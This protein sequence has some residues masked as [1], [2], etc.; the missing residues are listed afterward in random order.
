MADPIIESGGWKSKQAA[1]EEEEGGLTAVAGFL[2]LGGLLT[3]YLAWAE[4]LWWSAAAVT[5]S[6]LAVRLWQLARRQRRERAGVPVP[7]SEQRS[8]DP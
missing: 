2:T 1:D 8:E 5:M 7:T 3:S 4:S 6:L